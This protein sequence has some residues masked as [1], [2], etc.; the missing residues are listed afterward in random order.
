MAFCIKS[1]WLRAGLLSLLLRVWIARSITFL[2]PKKFEILELLARDWYWDCV[3]G[4]S[5]NNP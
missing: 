2:V 5:D 1:Y 3:K 4:W